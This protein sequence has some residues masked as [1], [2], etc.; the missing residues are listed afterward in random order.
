MREEVSLISMHPF[1]RRFVLNIVRT[2]REKEF[3]GEKFVIDAEMVPKVSGDVMMASMGA[4]V[5]RPK[6]EKREKPVVARRDM[7]ELVAPIEKPTRRVVH[8]MAP[9]RAPP[10]RRVVAP[11]VK[12]ERVA[13]PVVGEPVAVVEDG[14]GKIIPLLNDPSVTTIECQGKDKELM[15]IRAGQRQRTR[16]VLQ[17]EE[18]TNILDKV[19]DE[20]HI[21]LIEGI[22]RAS[23]PE[24]SVSAVV[25]KTVGSR[26]VIKKV[27]AYNLIE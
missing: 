12:V 14:Y 7:S 23:L 25:S 2:I 16:I 3:G 11:P 17:D 22:F 8:A 5:V 15:I 21:P 1:V 10:V 19:A 9:R 20:T 18:I 27:T 24:F 26:F 6:L 4:G 13:P